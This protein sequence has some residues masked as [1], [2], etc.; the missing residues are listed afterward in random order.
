MNDLIVFLNET[1]EMIVEKMI[2]KLRVY[3][4]QERYQ[5]QTIILIKYFN[6]ISFEKKNSSFLTICF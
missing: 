5:T 3:S 4:L 2:E 6:I 1:F